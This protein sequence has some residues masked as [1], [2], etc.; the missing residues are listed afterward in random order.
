MVF[1]KA[2]NKTTVNISEHM[3]SSFYKEP[4]DF[5][6]LLPGHRKEA[7]VILKVSMLPLYVGFPDSS[8]SKNPPAMQET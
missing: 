4:Y 1:Y 7:W 6:A 5:M 8:S 3:M 2:K